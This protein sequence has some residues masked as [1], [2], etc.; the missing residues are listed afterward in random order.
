MLDKEVADV[1]NKLNSME[2]DYFMEDKKVKLPKHV[3][4]PILPAT[5]RSYAVVKAKDLEELV[6]TVYGVKHYDFTALERCGNMTIHQFH[7]K[8]QVYP[9]DVVDIKNMKETGFICEYLGNAA[10]LD[11]LCFDKHIQPGYYLIEVD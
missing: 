4:H 5:Y 10:L 8:P 3:T 11:C 7:V 2:T 6:K 1:V 9:S